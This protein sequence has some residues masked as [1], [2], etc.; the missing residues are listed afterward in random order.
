MKHRGEINLDNVPPPL[1]K[2]AQH[3]IKHAVDMKNE[4]TATLKD[5]VGLVKK[6]WLSLANEL[7]F[8]PGSIQYT[9]ME[10]AFFCGAYTIMQIIK[11]L[12]DASEDT[13]FATLDSIDQECELFKA[14]MLFNPELN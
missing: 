2:Q 11:K 10:K 14:A 12:E 1:M 6:A 13:A 5:E 7:Q 3:A 9:E 4:A 8:T